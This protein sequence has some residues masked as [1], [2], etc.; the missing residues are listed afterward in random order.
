MR[1]V[2]AL[3][4]ALRRSADCWYAV[5]GYP[6]S[7]LA[8]ATGALLTTN[9]KVALEYALGDSLAGRRAAVIVKHVG[10]N[11]CADPLV[12]ATA[13]GLRAGV[14]VVVGDD[15]RPVGSDVT[16][17]SRYYGEVAQVP[18]LEPDGEVIAPAIEAAF[19]ASETFSRVAIIRVTPDL[20]DADV[21]EIH[22]PR[23]DRRG[24]LMDPGLTMAGR[25]QVSD[26][27][28]R[29]MFA[30]SRS[31]PLN[32]ISGGTVGAGPVKGVSSRAVTVYPP[33]ASLDLLADTREIGRPFLAEHRHIAPPKIAGEPERFSSRGYSR[34]FC[35]DC[36]FH[37]TF[38]ILLDGGM[39]AICDA[40]CAI[41]AMNP[42]YS[43]GIAS[44]GLGSS[45][46]VAATGTGVAL[47]GDYAL[48]H[49][50]LNALIDVY[51]RRLPLLC[52]VLANNRM[53]MTGGHPVPDI[54]RYITWADPV[55]CAADDETALRR[56]LVTP[57]EP[58][59]VVIEGTC[60]GGAYHETLEY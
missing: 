55:V 59:T 57:T 49:S 47:T 29:A 11:A 58:C 31:S 45:V 10:L 28:T 30:W 22:A 35:R 46:A 19:E 41:L 27:G 1:G 4:L 14:V 37:P 50:G 15:V 13:Q 18:V 56:A 7:E 38:A 3:A 8:A 40:G 32:R 6:V 39:R 12:H 43:L 5:P 26:Q 60:P 20:L 51:A 34:T 33:P 25:A 21:P 9:E 23:S 53:G 42:P 17:D 44:Y 16:G 2:E 54:L 52:I 24:S 36:P 48:I